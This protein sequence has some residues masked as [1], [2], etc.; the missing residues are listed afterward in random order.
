MFIDDSKYKRNG[1]TYRRVL[2]R[3]SYRVEGKVQHDTI[4]NLS[5][6]SDAE[7]N[8]LKL[9]LQH[10]DD[11]QSL[12]SIKDLQIKQG[13]SIGA[14]WV[15]YKLS[16]QLGITKALGNERLSKLALWLIMACV[17]SP[18]SRLSAT[19]LAQ[20]H[21]ICNIL[22]LD[23]FTEND[24]Y[25]AMD[26]LAMEQQNI[27]KS[28][29]N[30][31]YGTNK[32][33][34]Y[35]YDVTSS[36]FE[37]ECNEL[38]NYGYN[39]DKKKGKKQIVIGLMTD[40]EG[41]P[42]AIEVFEGNTQ[43]PKTVTNQIK[44]MASRFEVNEVTLV[45]DRGM[46][47]QMQIDELNDNNFHYITAITKPQIEALINKEV[48]QLSLFDK[49]IVEVKDNGA[50][51]VLHR[52]PIRATEIANSRDAKL[53]YLKKFI[54]KKNE[55]L[56]EHKKA[57]AETALDKVTNKAKTLAIVKWLNI[58]LNDRVISVEINKQ[59][60][61]QI[62]RLDGCYV[63]KT[64]LTTNIA[65]AQQIHSRYKDLAFV[66]T[67][68]RTM[69]TTLLEMRGIYVRKAN[70]TRAHVFVVMLAYLIAHHLHK[71]WYKIETTVEE[72]IAELSSICSIELTFSQ[73]A[74]S[75]QTIPEPRTMGMALLISL[76]IQLP[77]IIPTNNGQVATTKK[78]VSER[79]K[80]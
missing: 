4:A 52:N 46:I 28:L 7:I 39:R 73:Q 67:A 2:L 74:I 57:K 17:I 21:H 18:G 13:L 61:E 23:S 53:A 40:D 58:Q 22:G 19:R 14:V 42:I 34:F 66:E 31:R 10:K 27:E 79:K 68:F 36:Y 33:N 55:Y 35:L 64:D 78:L 56:A 71:C 32:P 65:D 12:F 77:D 26:W 44:K 9:A 8:A 80:L 43:D 72:G 41:I 49:K 11:L 47:K 76:G 37:G 69:K 30:F 59:E 45:G 60:L 3:N 5:S 6:C 25:E 75:C 1:K 20:K 24:L 54:A 70:R 50:R 38:A 62:A 16:Q 51:Y 15:L 48:F 29:F 63:I